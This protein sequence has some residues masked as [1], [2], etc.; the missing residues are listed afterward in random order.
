PTVHATQGTAMVSPC[1]VLGSAFTTTI[2]KADINNVE[3]AAD[4]IAVA[5]ARARTSPL[6]F[7]EHG[8]PVAEHFCGRT[9]SAHVRRVIVQPDHRV[10]ADRNCMVDEQFERLLTGLFAHFCVSA[11]LAADD[12]FQAAKDALADGRGADNQ[13]A[14]DAEVA[15]DAVAFDCECGRD[16]NGHV[17]SPYTASGSGSPAAG[18]TANAAASSRALTTAKPATIRQSDA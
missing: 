4:P 7:D 13:A 12:R 5:K 14:N 1:M 2:P 18:S 3:M 17:A 9:L 15:R 16:G 6:R 8:G 11:D 10:S